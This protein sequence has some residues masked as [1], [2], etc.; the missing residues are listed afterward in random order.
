MRPLLILVALAGSMTLGGCSLIAGPIF[1]G[2]KDA[3]SDARA[4]ADL[5]NANV[6]ML[7]YSIENGGELP[8]TPAQLT[9]YGYSQ[10]PG[11]SEVTIMVT[12][13]LQ[14]CLD[15]QSSTGTSFWVDADG[16]MAEGSC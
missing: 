6:A 1:E 10:S 11:V 15:V 5:A 7:S 9:D 4:Q 16:N 3:A 12:G 8:T 13:E 14:Y 2:Q